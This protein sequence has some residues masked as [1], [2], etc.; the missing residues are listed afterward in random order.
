MTLEKQATTS[1]DVGKLIGSVETVPERGL[2][3]STRSAAPRWADLYES[4]LLL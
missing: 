4:Q 2:P 3:S 1:I